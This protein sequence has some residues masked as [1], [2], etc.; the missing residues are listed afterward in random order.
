V[1]NRQVPV[2]VLEPGY[3]Q[4]DT[5]LVRPQEDDLAAAVRVIQRHLAA[6]DHMEDS[7]CSDPVLQGRWADIWPIH[8]APQA[9]LCQTQHHVNVRVEEAS[10]PAS[11]TGKH[12]MP[13]AAYLALSG[14]RAPAKPTLRRLGLGLCVFTALIGL[15][16]TVAWWG[17]AD[18]A[19]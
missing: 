5:T 17:R 4:G 8:G 19:G 7:R 1:D 9:R 10:R 13:K 6:R 18:Q 15:A 3:F 11:T 14:Q 12:T 16:V 2:V